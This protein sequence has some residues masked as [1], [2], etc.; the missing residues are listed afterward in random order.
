[1]PASSI[2]GTNSIFS[3]GKMTNR[4][5]H[6]TT[7]Q[8]ADFDD[9]PVP[10]WDRYVLPVGTPIYRFKIGHS[11]PEKFVTTRTV[12]FTAKD[13]VKEYKMDDNIT[14]YVFALPKKA[15][16]WVN[17]EVNVKDLHRTLKGP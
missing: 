1:V 4:P 16:P 9:P 11:V 10:V 12:I 6:K 14:H 8:N 15:H 7:L 5:T 17:I 2:S 13:I 3:D